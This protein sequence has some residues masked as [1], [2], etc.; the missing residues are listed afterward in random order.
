[1]DIAQRI[2]LGR[3]LS[4]LA[5]TPLMADVPDALDLSRDGNSIFAHGKNKE[6][7]SHYIAQAPVM[8]KS[9][10]PG[11]VLFEHPSLLRTFVGAHPRG[12]EAIGS[13][14]YQA[15]PKA[16]IV[17]LISR[18]GPDLPEEAKGQLSV[19]YN[20]APGFPQAELGEAAMNIEPFYNWLGDKV[21]VPLNAIGV[22]IVPLNGIG[23]SF[24]PYPAF[25]GGSTGMAFGNLP[26]ERSDQFI[27]ASIWRTE[28]PSD[29]CKLYI[30]NLQ[31]KQWQE[32]A[33]LDW[34]VYKIGTS[35]V[36]DSPWLLYGSRSP[37]A[38]NAEGEFYAPQEGQTGVRVPKLA[39]LIA[40]SG[41]LESVPFQGNP[42]WDV[43]MEPTGRYIAY[44]DRRRYAMV[45]VDPASGMT[46]IDPRW[47][48]DD[49]ELKV[50]VS[51]GGD[52]VFFWRG[53]ILVR[54]EWTGHEDGTGYED[55]VA[56]G[57]AGSGDDIKPTA[58][59]L[60]EEDP[61]EEL[62]PSGGGK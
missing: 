36:W 15:N 5:N 30:L 19:A 22:G 55:A 10:G 18:F 12:K 43:G 32:V 23:I 49:V 60:P 16:P 42:V 47:W 56:E 28:G 35:S 20:T 51:E 57:A 45:R 7:G 52:K 59:D 4:W 21:I 13:S 17:D 58:A 3:E 48:S 26:D 1:M 62:P 46:D 61:E 40:S 9:L 33:T 38:K 29:V 6:N 25:D 54:G 24:V 41:I 50:F 34:A 27:W 31:T 39:R 2:A 11:K 37:A 8:E 53:D 44:M 14:F